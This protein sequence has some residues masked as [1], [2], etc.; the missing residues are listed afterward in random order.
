[1]PLPPPAVPVDA[2]RVEG[3]RIPAVAGA[4]SGALCTD[5]DGCETEPVTSP[6]DDLER[7]GLESKRCDSPLHPAAATEIPANRARRNQRGER[8]GSAA[9][10]IG[11]PTRTQQDEGAVNRARVNKLLSLKD[12]FNPNGMRRKFG[13]PTQIRTLAPS[14]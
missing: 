5:L 6:A 12:S 2:G 1:M 14:P 13:Q 9:Q 7:N 10:R 3:G 8:S 4:G 11:F